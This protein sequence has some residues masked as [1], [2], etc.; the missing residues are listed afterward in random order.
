M[1]NISFYLQWFEILVCVNH[2]LVTINS[3]VN[4]LI[5]LMGSKRKTG[6]KGKNC[7]QNNKI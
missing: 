3:S 7:T 6:N 1:K 5:Y 4:F 2:L